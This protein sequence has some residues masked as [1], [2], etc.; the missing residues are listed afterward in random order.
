LIWKL[1]LIEDL[2]HYVARK[3]S[4]AELFGRQPLDLTDPTDR[5]KI[6]DSIECDFSPENVSCDG[7]LSRDM[8]NRRL[9]E[10][11]IVAYQLKKLDPSIKFTELA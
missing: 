2:E 1:T 7:E 3:N 8:V 11:A 6:A 4:L 10:L 9:R 5:Q